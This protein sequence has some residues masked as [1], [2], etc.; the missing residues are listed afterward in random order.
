MGETD[1]SADAAEGEV[2]REPKGQWKKCRAADANRG[3]GR[4]ERLRERHTSP[5]T[6]QRERWRVPQRGWP[7]D[8]S[9]SPKGNHSLPS[10][11]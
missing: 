2:E 8:S 5:R 3:R 4:E 1:I 9:G 7:S 10:K 11:K 6:R